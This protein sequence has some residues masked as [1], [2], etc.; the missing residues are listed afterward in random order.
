MV[1]FGGLPVPGATVTATQA[2]KR[3]TAITD[4]QGAYFF[5][6]LPDGV[7]KVRVEML[8]FAPLEREV[9]VTAQ[10]PAPDWELKLLPLEQ[11]GAVAPPPAAT[12]AQ[13]L[14]APAAPAAPA[15][16]PSKAAAPQPANT[17]SGFQRADLNASADAAKLAPD[18]LSA[19]PNEVSPAPSD[20]FLINGSVN[21]GAASPFAQSAAFGNNR[22]RRSQ[23]NGNVGLTFDD[24]SL[25][26]RAFSLT[27][28]DTAK[29]AYTK[30]TGLLSLG[31][32]LNIPHVMPRGPNV[33]LNYQ[34]TRNRNAST[35]TGLVPTDLQRGGDFSQS[36]NA[37]GRPVVATDPATGEPFPNDA[38]PTNRFSPQATVLMGLYP[39]ANFAGGAR[40]NYQIPLVSPTHTDSLQMRANKAI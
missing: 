33:T 1:K 4:Q 15:K 5:A 8:C 31:G 36:L 28:Q 7:W 13:A 24:S 38:V 29:P 9:A 20:G 22:F 17:A 14:A 21:N 16:K 27:G 30:A 10:A 2:D 32:P 40:Y 11:M 12:A 34:W 3:F 39:A 23:Y 18:S 26:A 25:D 19:G 6:D 35:Y 37:Q